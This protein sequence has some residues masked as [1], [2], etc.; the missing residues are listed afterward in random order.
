M[1]SDTRPALTTD[2][3]AEEIE[4]RLRGE[5]PIKGSKRDRDDGKENRSTS[6]A[7]VEFIRLWSRN[8]GTLLGCGFLGWLAHTTFTMAGDVR[9]LLDRPLPVPMEQYRHDQQEVRDQ[10]SAQNAKLDAMQNQ[11]NN[12]KPQK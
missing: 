2:R 4:R 8:F 5:Y 3:E 11:L 1:N 10:L 9:V 12:L 7:I 6:Q